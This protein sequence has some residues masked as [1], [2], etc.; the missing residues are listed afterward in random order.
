M[1]LLHSLTTLDPEPVQCLIGHALNVCVLSYST[2]S[3]ELISGSWDKTA[4]VWVEENGEWRTKLVLD[5]HAQAVWGVVGIDEGE[6]AGGYLT[7]SGESVRSLGPSSEVI[8]GYL[9][10]SQR[11]SW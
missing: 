7:G 4:R 8:R 6:H 10:E 3:R 5:E 9:A 1:I 2:K 11:T